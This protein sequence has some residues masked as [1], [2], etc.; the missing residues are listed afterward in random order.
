[1]TPLGDCVG[2]MRVQQCAAAV[3]VVCTL[4]KAFAAPAAAVCN[5]Y[6]AP[7]LC[8]NAG[9]I[10]RPPNHLSDPAFTVAVLLYLVSGLR[11]VRLSLTAP[12]TPASPCPS[13]SP[14]WCGL[15]PS[16]LVVLRSTGTPSWTQR[17]ACTQVGAA[18]GCVERTSVWPGERRSV[19]PGEQQ[20]LVMNSSSS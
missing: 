1:V 5:S 14:S 19:W 9:E 16:W 2:F 18:Q 10:S 20:Q 13:Q 7:S 4:Q 11:L 17:G 6:C 8:T 15:R 12:P 3:V